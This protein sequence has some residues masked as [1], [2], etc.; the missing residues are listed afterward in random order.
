[1]ESFSLLA[2]LISLVLSAVMSLWGL[3]S[4]EGRRTRE[5][6]TAA[7]SG[8]TTSRKTYGAG[9][10]STMMLV[11]ALLCLTMSIAARAAITGHGPFSNMYEFSV[12]FCWGITASTLYF[13]WRYR[14]KVMTT[15][16]VVIAL[17]LLAY[18]YTLP[19]R[20]VPLQPALQQSLMLSFHVAAAMVAYTQC[21]GRDDGREDDAF[22]GGDVH[23]IHG[24]VD[25]STCHS[26]VSGMQMADTASKTLKWVGIGFVGVVV[27][28]M[29]LNYVVARGRLNGPEVD[30]GKPDD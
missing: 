3:V 9:L 11:L 16:G 21:H 29:A 20:H 19:S 27:A 2:A 25:C 15:V 17:A 1:M 18:A 26:S 8:D 4:P 23:Q 12:A 14:M 22:E 24:T 13:Q 10:S 30:D 28:G 6:G 5:R 7:T